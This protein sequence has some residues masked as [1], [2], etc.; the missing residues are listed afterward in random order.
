MVPVEPLKESVLLEVL[1]AILA[2]SVFPTADESLDEVLGLL[3]HVG[4]MRRE[5]KPLLGSGQ[6][7]GLRQ[8]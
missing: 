7:A 8:P 1:D 2:Q 3:G 5:L 4:D 6:E